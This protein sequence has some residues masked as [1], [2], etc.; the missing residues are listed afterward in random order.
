MDEHTPGP[1]TAM[2]QRYR[3]H[4]TGRIGCPC[5]ITHSGGITLPMDSCA[6]P[7][8][9]A[10]AMLIAAAPD[11]LHEL[12]RCRERFAGSADYLRK[13]HRPSMAEEFDGYARD[14]DA[15]IARAAGRD[16]ES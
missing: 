15:A 11:L 12:R 16:G 1:W 14:C 13:R 10:N 7:E 5:W 9:E 8:A 2:S 6:A 3:D 4:Q